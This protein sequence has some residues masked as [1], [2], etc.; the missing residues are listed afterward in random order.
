MIPA[1]LLPML[2]YDMPQAI[3]EAA[4]ASTTNAA[5]VY[6]RVGSDSEFYRALSREY[7]VLRRN[8]SELATLRGVSA[9]QAFVRNISQDDKVYRRT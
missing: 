9:E 3:A 6:R 2:L 1:R 7:T 8:E 4:A 5:D